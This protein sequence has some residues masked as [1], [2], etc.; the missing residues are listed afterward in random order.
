MVERSNRYDRPPHTFP[1]VIPVV[2]SPVLPMPLEMIQATGRRFLGGTRVPLEGE[3]LTRE[4][5]K[6]GSERERALTQDFWDDLPAMT[7]TL[8]GR[9]VCAMMIEA[10]APIDALKFRC[11]VAEGIREKEQRVS[12]QRE[13][14]KRSMGVVL[15][16]H[17]R[18]NRTNLAEAA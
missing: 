2:G 4:P 9:V 6:P 11:A 10:M 5:I 13:K 18:F 3:I 7:E 17:K 12:M 14:R 1:Q 15:L 8:G 16:F